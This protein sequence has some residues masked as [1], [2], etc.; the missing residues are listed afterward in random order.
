MEGQR[1]YLMNRV[2]ELE[3]RLSKTE[4]ILNEILEKLS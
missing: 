4:K 2:M 1:S 3:A